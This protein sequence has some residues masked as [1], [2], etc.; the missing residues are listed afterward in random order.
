MSNQIYTRVEDAVKDELIKIS[1]R[2]RLTLAK[3]YEIALV[4]YIER[5]RVHVVIAGPEY[6]DGGKR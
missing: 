1:K 6:I 5:N 3:I 4:E 2:K